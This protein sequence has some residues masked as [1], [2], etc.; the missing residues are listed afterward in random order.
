MIS[1]GKIVGTH[2]LKGT[3]KIVSYAESDDIFS[4]G[5]QINA[6]KAGGK[7]ESLTIIWARPHKNL[8]LICFKEIDSIEKC[9]EFVGADLLIERHRLPETEDGTY[10]WVDLIGLSVYTTEG[11]YL[12]RLDNIFATGSNDIYVVK[13]QEA[14]NL[15]PALESVVREIDLENRVMRVKIPEGL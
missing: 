13:N 4:K 11:S 5:K 12:G 7:I 3:V 9:R 10:Y 2:G 1:I 14:E 6:Q 8:I 15:I